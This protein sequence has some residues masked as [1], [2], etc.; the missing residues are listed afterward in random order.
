MG[1]DEPLPGDVLEAAERLT[2]R[3]RAASDDDEAAAYRAER[4]ELLAAHGYAARVREDDARDVLVC[5]P[6][7][8]IA[9]GVIRVE[10]I[11]DRSR[12]VEIPL[13]GPGEPDDWAAVDAHNRAVAETV[14][15]RHGEPHGATARALADFAGNHYAKPIE[16]LTCEER[17]E[18]REEYLPRNAW[19]SDAQ[20]EQV[21]ESVRLALAVANAETVG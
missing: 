2:R 19:P 3:A 10:A 8:W 20:R 7:E 5:Y 6:A 13:S 12:A 9:E 21:E 15:D 1:G 17:R 14:A 4:D 18:F 16:E 11:E